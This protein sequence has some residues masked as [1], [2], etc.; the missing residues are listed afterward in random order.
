MI[1][2]T[3]NVQGI[4]RKTNEIIS[5]LKE[6][7][8]DIAVLT[9]TKKKGQGSENPGHYDHFFSGIAK[10]KRAQQGVSIFIRKGIRN[11]I[12]SWE[13]INER[14]I[15]MNFSFNG[16]KVTIIGVY[17]V[18]DDALV[19]K[20]DELFE[21]LSFEI[22]KIGHSREI[23]LLGDLNART[24]RKSGDRT[25]GQFGEDTTNDNGLR[26]ISMAEQNELKILNGFFQHPWI[27][28]FTWTQETRNLKS[29]I[30]YIIVRQKSKLK[31]NDVR[32]HRGP[33][34]G[35]DHHLLKAK[36]IFPPK[37]KKRTKPFKT[38]RRCKVLDTTSTAF[39]T[40]V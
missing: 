2:G 3:W 29:I 37:S 27:H 22:T 28:K 38:Q 14:L 18:N 9:E 36:V 17:A 20:K 26:L 30:D 12:T 1:I 15:K 35:S 33:T 19:N 32:V 40:K 6:L 31:F 16:Q 13:A 10:D 34:C 11:C 23:V 39:I 25:V 4:A 5:E 8:V 24:G 7:K 21:Q